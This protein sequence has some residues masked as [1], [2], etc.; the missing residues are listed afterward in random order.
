M[1]IQFSAI[2][3]VADDMHD[4][5]AFYRF[6]GLDIA[7]GAEERPHAEAELPGGI[8][9]MWDSAESMRSIDPTWSP[10]SG[11]HR[12][13]LAFGCASPEAVDRAY[14]EVT[15]AGYAGHRRPWDAPWGQRYATILDPDG[16][17]VDLFAAL[18]A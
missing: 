18:T 7:D 3:L 10:P 8:R 15:G 17:P 14:A 11:G 6:L 16:N 9:L 4:T 5:L 1:R 13:A 2:G 12:A